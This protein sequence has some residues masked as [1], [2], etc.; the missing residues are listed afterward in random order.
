MSELILTDGG[1]ETTLVF[2]EGVELEHFAAF[3]LGD[4][5]RVGRRGGRVDRARQ[6]P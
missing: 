6:W 3:P 5:L 4:R 1:L 2:H